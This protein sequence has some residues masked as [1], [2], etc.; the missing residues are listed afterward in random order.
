MN[1]QTLT[2]EFVS[3]EILIWVRTLQNE[4]GETTCDAEIASAH[5]WGRRADGTG[6]ELKTFIDK[7]INTHK[8]TV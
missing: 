2:T 5:L 8:F 4:E 6:Q 1:T 7:D 3:T